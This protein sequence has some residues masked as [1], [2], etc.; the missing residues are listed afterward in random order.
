MKRIILATVVVVVGLAIGAVWLGGS[1]TNTRDAII[2]M[3]EKGA[4]ESEMLAVVDGNNKQPL[5][6]DDVIKMKQASVPNNV[7]S[8]MLQ[9]SGTH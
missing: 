9:K 1:R 4:S 6:A 7:I 2:K 8:E 3:V 5:N